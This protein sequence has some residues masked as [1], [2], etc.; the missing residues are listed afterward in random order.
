MA[1]D[2]TVEELKSK[3]DAG[4][5]FV[6]IDVREPHEYAEFNLGAKLI[7]LGSLTNN[8]DDLMPFKDE[9]IVIHCRSGMRSGNAKTTLSQMG[10]SNVRN[11]LGGVLEWQRLYGNVL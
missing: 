10:F 8:L 3:M 7:P 1:S 6:F 9:E 5:N 2:I 4:E 11:L